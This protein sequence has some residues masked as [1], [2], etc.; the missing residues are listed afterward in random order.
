M[1]LDEI[2]SLNT[3]VPLQIILGLEWLVSAEVGRYRVCSG[4]LTMGTVCRRLEPFLKPKHPC[5]FQSHPLF[6]LALHP[7][8]PS[9]LPLH[10]STPTSQPLYPQLSTPPPPLPPPL[11]PSTLYPSPPLPHP[12]SPLPPPPPLHLYP[13]LSTPLPLHPFYPTTPQ[14]YHSTLLPLHN[15]Y[16]ITSLLL[17]AI[18]S[19]QMV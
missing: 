14:P 16:A 13:H 17:C 11:Y 10:P 18:R 2:I 7:S 9:S 4:E 1:S 12:C 5:S 6:G 19:N 15:L 3:A 8:T